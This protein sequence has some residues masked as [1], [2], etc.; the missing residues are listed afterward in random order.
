MSI[1]AIRMQIIQQKD[2]KQRSL[3]YHQFFGIYLLSVFFLLLPTSTSY[4]KAISILQQPPPKASLYLFSP[5][6]NAFSQCSQSDFFQD[7]N[8][9]T[10]VVLRCPLERIQT[11]TGPIGQDSSSFIQPLCFLISPAHH[12]VSSPGP[13]HSSLLSSPAYP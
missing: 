6:A 4:I 11:L 9:D 5:N 7:I 12:R 1:E 8:L 3:V 13:L 10:S 2:N